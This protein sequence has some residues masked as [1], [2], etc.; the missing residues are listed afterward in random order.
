MHRHYYAKRAHKHERA[1]REASS[2][3][4]REGHRVIA[5]GYRKLA[6]GKGAKGGFAYAPS[7]GMRV[8]PYHGPQGGPSGIFFGKKRRA[9]AGRKAAKGRRRNKRGRFI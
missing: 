8:R 4:D 2:A 7:P 6:R 9:A 1:A 5:G 3:H